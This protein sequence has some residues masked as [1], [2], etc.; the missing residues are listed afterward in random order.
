[1]KF[2]R[3]RFLSCLLIVSMGCGIIDIEQP[4]IYEGCCGISSVEDS[5]GSIRF[6]I[7]SAI[8]PDGDSMNEYFSIYCSDILEIKSMMVREAHDILAI[9]RSDIKILGWR[10]L[11]VPKNVSGKVIY[12]LYDYELLLADEAGN[13]KTVSG[14]FCAFSCGQDDTDEI[15]MQDCHFR[16][17]SDMAGAFDSELPS[18]EDCP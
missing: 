14:Q 3:L 2:I 16:S 17:Q 5:I 8:T 4:N 7:P 18:L 1:M 10:N 9:Q 12:G 6:Y 13:E 11:W 15:P